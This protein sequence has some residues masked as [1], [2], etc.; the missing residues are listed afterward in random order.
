MIAKTRKF[1]NFIAACA[2]WVG[3]L[4][5]DASMIVGNVTIT[6]Y[7]TVHYLMTRR[8]QSGAASDKC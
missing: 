1:A 5:I 8:I 3:L 2:A 7:E 6:C 4:A